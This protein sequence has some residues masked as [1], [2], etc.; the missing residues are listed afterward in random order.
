M[1]TPSQASPARMF[2]LD[3][4][5]AL[6][7][8]A[9]SGFGERFATVLAAAGAKVACVARRADRVEAVAEAI[10]AA[11]GEA[12]P[13]VMDVTDHASMRAGFDAIEA[14]FGTV[15]VLVNNA[16]LSAP[17]PFAEMSNQQWDSVLDV[18]LSAPFY[19]AREMS[20]RLIARGRPGSIINIA[21]ILGHLAKAMF[22]NYGTTKGAMIHMTQYMALDLLP[23]GIRV[24]AIAPG[25]FPTEMTNP[26]FETDMGK[27][28]V[29]ALPP[30]R[31]GRLEELDGPLLLLAS[32]ASS[33]MNGTVLTVDYGHSI[34]LS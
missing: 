15:D 14:R 27:A 33:Y 30:G 32:D 8:G 4:R 17:A 1:T 31:L 3:G 10:R 2:S 28:E 13:C 22:V 16:G 18:N 34:R 7:T 19:V 9:S 24:N 6:V 25:Y 26:F 20:R 11:G 21:S 23:H 12:M 5:V 29:A